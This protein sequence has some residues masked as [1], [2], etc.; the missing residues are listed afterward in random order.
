MAAA[1]A[2][3][4]VDIEPRRREHPLPAPLTARVGVLPIQGVRQLHPAGATVDVPFVLAADAIEMP[5]EGGFDSCRKHGPA[6]L[7]PFAAGDNHL[8]D[9]ETDILDAQ[10]SALE[11]ARV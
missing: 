2:G 11:K 3:G 8:V 4:A 10:P 7:V 9:S 5:S 1:L 6:V